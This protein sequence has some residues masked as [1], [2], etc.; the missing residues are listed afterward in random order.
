MFEFPLQV[1]DDILRQY[2]VA[3]VILILFVFGVLAGFVKKSLKLTG[4]Q[5]TLFGL[6]FFLTPIS[7]HPMY[8]QYLGLG[9]IVVGPVVFI[10]AED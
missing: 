4:L 5:F 8:F 2:S 6:V 1:V 7:T 3:H 10:A 9:L